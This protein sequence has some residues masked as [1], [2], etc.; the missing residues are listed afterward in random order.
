ME[1]KNQANI[2]FKNKDFARSIEK[3]QAYLE[4]CSGDKEDKVKAIPY[5]NISA[6]YEQMGN[7]EEAMKYC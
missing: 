6:A 3:Y 1:T 5:Q 2:L 7:D 4:F